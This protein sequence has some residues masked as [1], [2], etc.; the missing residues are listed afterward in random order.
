MDSPPSFLNFQKDPIVVV[1]KNPNLTL[2][3]QITYGNRRRHSPYTGYH[4]VLASPTGQILKEIRSGFEYRNFGFS[5]D[6]ES[7]AF[8]SYPTLSILHAPDYEPFVIELLRFKGRKTRGYH[9]NYFVWDNDRIITSGFFQP[10]ADRLSGKGYP[11]IAEVSVTKDKI[12]NHW[13]IWTSLRTNSA[14]IPSRGKDQHSPF[15]PIPQSLT[16]QEGQC[17]WIRAG[18]QGAPLSEQPSLGASWML[19]NLS[20]GKTESM[21]PEEASKE[22]SLMKTTRTLLEEPED[23]RDKLSPHLLSYLN[24]LVKLSGE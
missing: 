24:S 23:K 17:F 21:S 9:I 5:R 11:F 10:D 18:L 6:G 14:P 3:C 20:N 15:H 4:F 12:L 22:A 7:L 2:T 1:A 16:S 13:V 8:L 19:T